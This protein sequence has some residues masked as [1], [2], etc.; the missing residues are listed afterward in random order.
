VP[1]NGTLSTVTIVLSLAL[2]A[3][4]LV[5]G[6]RDRPPDRTH[7]AGLALVELS[8]VALLVAALV[9]VAGGARPASAV[10]FV[11]YV[12]TVLCLPPLGYVLARLEPTRWGTVIIG[13]VCL[14]VPVLVL[15][16]Q[17]TWQAV[18]SG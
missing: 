12:V 15:R 1:V 5:T 8:L 9:S 17:Q 3:W 7:L 10:T 11:G 18:T 4:S 14:T 6:Y 2:A 13:V 16:L